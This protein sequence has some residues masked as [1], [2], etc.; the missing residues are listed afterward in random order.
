LSRP[1]FISRPNID[2][3]VRLTWQATGKQKVTFLESFQ[4]SCN[5]NMN[6]EA[7]RAP[8]AANDVKYWPVSLT[9]G[10][11]SY[12]VTNKLLLQAGATV[13]FFTFT[14]LRTNG[15][16]E[17]DIPITE[18][19]SGFLYRARPGLGLA[20]YGYTVGNQTNER[21]SVS[22][23]TGSHAVKAGVFY[24]LGLSENYAEQSNPP[25]QYLFRNGVPVTVTQ[26]AAPHFWK[27]R[28]H[29]L[30][31]YA[32]DQWT[33]NKLTLNLGV[34]LDTFRANAPAQ[35]R[36][37]GVFV[38]AIQ[39]PEFN[40]LVNWKDVEPRLG[41]AYDVFG[42]GK[43]AVKGSLGRYVAAE[44]SS[45]PQKIMPNSN[46]VLSA[47]RTWTDANLD[48]SPQ[49]NELGPL[50]DA[51]FGTVR[52]TTRYA[53]DVTTGWFARPHSWQASA[54]LQHELRP[55]VG[56]V[57]GYYRTSYGNISVNPLATNSGGVI[58]NLAVTPADYDPFCI[59]APLDP[60]L[61]GGGGN[62]I[63]GLF[64]IK[65]TAF[66]KVDNLVTQVS[67]FGKPSETFNGVDIST[68][69]RLNSGGL[70]SGGVSWGRVIVDNCYIIDSP[71]Q[72]FCK[73]TNPPQ[74]G[75]QITGGVQ[76][77]LQAVY[78]LPRAFQLSA[79]LQNL[80]GIPRLATYI[81]T[82][83]QIAP[84]LGRN[85]GQ[86]GASAVC[87]GTFAVDMIEPGTEFENRLNAVDLKLARIFR[88][89]RARIEANVDAYNIF[90]ASAIRAQ[91]NGYGGT[92]LRPTD[93][94][95]GRLFKVGAQLT[96]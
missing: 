4:D 80:Q 62:Q 86:C 15:A 3:S 36:P 31:Y 16:T 11:W 39:F 18:L 92:W 7:N 73:V 66:G 12:P 64:D 58:D 20:D 85:L 87:N 59:T 67:H 22:Y 49:E 68:N 89:G 29:N 82:N 81:A 14:N 38:P 23:I 57:V 72:R 2:H 94:I 75:G 53:D 74:I 32:Q 41:I 51:A 90:N 79:V 48:Y 26:W 9:Q 65:P 35:T 13:G 17:A 55:G 24:Y 45:L 52:T 28:S 47:N 61:P 19:S 83:A 50:S 5:C 56:L 43:T 71:Q 76:V 25:L 44:Q 42:N 54:V 6:I 93:V 40:N 46:I 88:I 95:L 63:C 10:T 77:K 78:P 30:A 91:V 69:A 70:L 1:G 33:L 8:E 34:R 96:F 37:A 84:S 21:F 27:L 60:R